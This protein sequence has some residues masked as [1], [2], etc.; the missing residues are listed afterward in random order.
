[1]HAIKRNASE[2]GPL[3]QAPSGEPKPHTSTPSGANPETQP[4]GH[5]SAKGLPLRLPASGG[6]EPTPEDFSSCK[7][8][9]S[10]PNKGL[11]R[12]DTAGQYPTNGWQTEGTG[13]SSRSLQQSL[14]SWE[15][16]PV[17][18]VPMYMYV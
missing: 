3:V 1:M 12:G 17:A 15:G 16:A 6:G 4:R 7:A 11:A 13:I 14:F 8:R 5:P 10:N 9:L 18:Q 2:A